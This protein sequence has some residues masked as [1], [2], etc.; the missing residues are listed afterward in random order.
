MNKIV[1]LLRL[2]VM[3]KYSTVASAAQFA[4]PDTSPHSLLGTA[5]SNLLTEA[6]TVCRQKKKKRCFVE[7]KATLAP[8]LG[9]NLVTCAKVKWLGLEDNIQDL[10]PSAASPII[11]N[12]AGLKPT[13]CIDLGVIFHKAGNVTKTWFET[14]FVVEQLWA[15]MELMLGGTMCENAKF[16]AGDRTLPLR[17]NETE[18]GNCLLLSR[19][20]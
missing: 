15:D 3:T 8:R 14:F 20:A 10:E 16:A 13:G 5:N 7:V 6:V 12:E 2:G 4:S 9:Y 19:P 18:E 17:I 11:A 1:S